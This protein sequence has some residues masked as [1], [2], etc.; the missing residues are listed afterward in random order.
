MRDTIPVAQTSEDLC[1][2]SRSFVG[3]GF[4]D[5]GKSTVR[6]HPDRSEGSA[7]SQ[8][9]RKMQIPR[10]KSA[11]EMAKLEFFRSL[12]RRAVNDTK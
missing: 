10:A 3:H 4:T 7:F 8:I 9:P 1:G 5:F 2:S 6:C 12:F 11:L